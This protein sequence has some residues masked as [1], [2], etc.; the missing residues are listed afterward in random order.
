MIK[1]LFIFSLFIFT[2][3][4]IYTFFQ[5]SK[6]LKKNSIEQPDLNKPP[7]EKP[8]LS[9]E[10]KHIQIKLNKE[11]HLIRVEVPAYIQKEEQK[12]YKEKFNQFYEEIQDISNE[13]ITFENIF[14]DEMKNNYGN[15]STSRKKLNF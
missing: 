2:I 11:S 12:N 4:F 15:T 3:F 7:V 8:K 13:P 14:R 10:K 1:L 6:L 9:P 5:K